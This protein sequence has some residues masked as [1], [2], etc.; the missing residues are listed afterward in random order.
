M[1]AT[2]N[3]NLTPE[4]FLLGQPVWHL[5]AD[6]RSLRWKMGIVESDPELALKGEMQGKWDRISRE[7]MKDYAISEADEWRVKSRCF[8]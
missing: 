4:Q 6:N 1:P 5:A 7:Q 2:N 3:S 8:A